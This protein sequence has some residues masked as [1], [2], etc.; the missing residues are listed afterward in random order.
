MCISNVKAPAGLEEITPLDS[1]LW[2]RYNPVAIDLNI[3][4]VTPQP[5]RPVKLRL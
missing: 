5:Y 1:A 2:I 3:A 4:A